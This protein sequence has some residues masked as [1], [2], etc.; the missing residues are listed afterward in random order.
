MM[1]LI[2][3][4]LSVLLAAYSV[5]VEPF[6]RTSFYRS[7]KKQLG[8]IPAARVQFYRRQVGWEWAWVVVI[9]LIFL[10]KPDQISLIGVAL[11]NPT[12]W[13]LM[14]IML[15]GGALLIYLNWR[16]P[17]A[18]ENIR[19]SLASAPI[20]RPSTAVERGWFIAVALTA[21]ICE[22]LLYRGFFIFFLRT[23]LP[24]VNTVILLSLL[25]GI[26][27]GLSRAYLGNRGII[28]TGI[29]GFLF[30]IILSLSG[31]LLPAML[32]HFLIEL[33]SLLNWGT[34]DNE[35]ALM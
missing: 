6:V 3:Y 7:L 17:N 35:K 12:G 4:Y 23:N 14:G 19:N 30:A 11:P 18:L 29:M 33:S 10:P 27:Y 8:V 2:S 24:M 16:S 26:V 5:L 31:S 1:D 22:E 32:L 9:A 20:L 15:V 21:G 28:Q 25:S 34:R 13:I